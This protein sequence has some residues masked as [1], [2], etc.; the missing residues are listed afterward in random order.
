M[1]YRYETRNYVFNF[2][3]KDDLT[4]QLRRFEESLTRGELPPDISFENFLSMCGAHNRNNVGLGVMGI[5]SIE[6][7]LSPVTNLVS[8]V[9][10]G[11]T[12]NSGSEEIEYTTL[13]N[14]SCEISYIP[15]RIQ[16]NFN[17]EYYADFIEN[18]PQQS[19][20]NYRQEYVQ[21]YI[22]R[23]CL[24]EDKKEDKKKDNKL[25][26]FELMDFDK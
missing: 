21:E 9:D 6:P 13:T 4:R 7:N 10:Y 5:E 18:P 14:S 25:N 20:Q 16:N 12:Y 8:G 15:T 2:K 26:R 22:N 17:Q 19:M 1:S 3:D 23:K 11:Q 24:E